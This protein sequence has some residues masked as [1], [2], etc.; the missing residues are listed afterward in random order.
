[1]INPYGVSVW[2]LD[3]P[4]SIFTFNE[5]LK[6]SQFSAIDS[7]FVFYLSQPGMLY[8]LL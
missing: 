6:F 5:N 2:M 1:M 8:P 4:E 3:N 7:R